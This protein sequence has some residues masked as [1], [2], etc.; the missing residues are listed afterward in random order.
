MFV[1]GE[2][3]VLGTTLGAK[4]V[5]LFTSYGSGTEGIAPVNY[6]LFHAGS[7]D[8]SGNDYFLMCLATTYPALANTVITQINM[9]GV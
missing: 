5:E 2:R 7:Q 8:N 6:G 4:M 3:L 1:P 9:N